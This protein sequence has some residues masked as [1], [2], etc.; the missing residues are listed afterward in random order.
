V[1]FK[2]HLFDYH[3]S[4]FQVFENIS[5]KRWMFFRQ[6]LQIVHCPLNNYPPAAVHHQKLINRQDEY[7]LRQLWKQIRM[8]RLLKT[9]NQ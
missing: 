9:K 5:E 7:V 1:V 2:N 3:L 6:F 4:I 8:V